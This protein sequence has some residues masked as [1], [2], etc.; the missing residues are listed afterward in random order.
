MEQFDCPKCKSKNVSAKQATDKNEDTGEIEAIDDLWECHC[1]D[2][3]WNFLTVD[4]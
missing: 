3:G 1:N 4:L 2:C